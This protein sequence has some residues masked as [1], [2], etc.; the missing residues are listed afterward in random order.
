MR[1]ERM[2]CG[3]IG[4]NTELV[5]KWF[6]I[7]RWMSGRACIFSEK[8]QWE[9]TY[10]SISYEGHEMGTIFLRGIKVHA[11]MY[12]EFEGLPIALSCVI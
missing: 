8:K 12:G 4:G 5:S 10:P 6:L 1:P 11:K 2:A 9:L 3:S 7:Q